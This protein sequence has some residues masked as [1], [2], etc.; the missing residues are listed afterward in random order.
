MH[1]LLTGGT[2]F[3]GSVLS[4]R[5]HALGH[6]LTVLSRT[7][8][9]PAPGVEY[10]TTLDAI[11]AQ[12]SLDA[13]INLAGASLAGKRWSAAYKA[14]L[15]DSRVQTTRALVALCQR[16][17]RAPAVML[18][19]SA[20][21][22]YGGR[23]EEALDENSEP[24]SGF[25]AELCRQ[26][27]QSA[28]PVTELGVRLC[29]LRLGV[30]FDRRGGAFEELVRPFRFGVANWIGDGSQWLSWVHREDVVAA[31]R[32]LLERG[33]LHGAFNITAPGPLDNRAL[34]AAIKRHQRTVITVPM[35]AP[36]MRALVGE[37]ANE[38]LISG[39]RVLPTRLTE[40]G[41]SFQYPQIDEALAQMLG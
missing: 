5:L 12:A 2:G 36:V 8:R 33:D 6:S 25:S 13:I 38:L 11:E 21:G 3:I 17:E 19:A 27:E 4:A 34:C 35:P 16:L 15:V 30:V 1:I 37:M 29:L 28:Q 7:P 40:A 23:G 31:C 22:F 39:Q 10:I 9:A 26:W 18:S 32:F 41:F 20:V 24:G 14:E